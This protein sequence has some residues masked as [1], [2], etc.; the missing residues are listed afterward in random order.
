LIVDPV[1]VRGER[2]DAQDAALRI[3]K[4]ATECSAELGP[5]TEVVW[6][7]RGK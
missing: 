5:V 1:N 4:L 2:P 7:G 6:A 3:A